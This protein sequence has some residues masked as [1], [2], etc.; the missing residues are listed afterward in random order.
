MVD[1]WREEQIRDSQL[2]CPEGNSRPALRVKEGHSA[3]RPVILENS[4][5]PLK[6]PNSFLF[7]SLEGEKGGSS[8]PE[9]FA[10]S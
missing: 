2:H 9:L 8:I 7:N 10:Y 4:K 3:S 6:I 5:F 1:Y